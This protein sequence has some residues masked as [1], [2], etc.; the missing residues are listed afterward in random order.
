MCP[1][2][3]ELE[4]GDPESPVDFLCQVAHLR[5][6][7]LDISVR[8]HGECEYCEGGDSYVQITNLAVF[9]KE[10]A[11]GHGLISDESFENQRAVV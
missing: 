8:P 2:E 10:K 4:Q 3:G 7:A 5:S 9:L 1:A 6:Y 11:L